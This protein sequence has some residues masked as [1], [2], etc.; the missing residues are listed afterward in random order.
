[1][2]YIP[3]P[4]EAS[5]PPLTQTDRLIYE[6]QIQLP[7]LGEPGQRILKR[8]SVMISRV[9]GLGGS[10]AVM[11]ARAGIGR[12]ILAHDGEVEHENV[13]RMLLTERDDIGKPRIEVFARTLK[14]INPDVELVTEGESVSE[15]NAR[16]LIEPAD[17]VVDGAP[18]FEERYAMNAEA[19]RQ[20]KPLVM[21]AMYALEGYVSTF[22]PGR[23]PCL[24]C[25][26]PEPP[27]YW[28]LRVFPVIA[29]ISVLVASV[30]AME[31]V[32]LLTGSCGEPLAGKL[33]HCDLSSNTF[34]TL[35]VERRAD[36][37]VC[38]HLHG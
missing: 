15:A 17:V 38:G 32:K 24:S 19:V 21:A 5:L 4:G 37:T 11:L 6:R 12:L 31:V 2:T 23:T 20:G 14:R 33:L 35:E 18:L 16:R 8:S 30:A 9:G 1:M 10:V 36:C 26:Y 22:V 28:N 13:N 3:C 29:P 34:R 25:L 7:E 27:D